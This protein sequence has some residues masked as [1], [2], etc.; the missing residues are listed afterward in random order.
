MSTV[1]TFAIFQQLLRRSINA[2]TS[3]DSTTKASMLSR[4]D[5]LVQ[6]DLIVED[7]STVNSNTGDASVDEA[8]RVITLGATNPSRVVFDLR[9]FTVPVTISGADTPKGFLTGNIGTGGDPEVDLADVSV[10]YRFSTTD[11]WKNL[12]QASLLKGVTAIQFA[13]DIVTQVAAASLPQL[14][15][16]P[17]QE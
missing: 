6:R 15:F 1:T 8:N 3:L 5:A 17:T 4:V 9:Q 13:V 10:Q 14:L 11:T 16:V 7:F 2:D 12:S